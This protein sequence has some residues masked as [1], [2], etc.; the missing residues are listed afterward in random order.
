MRDPDIDLAD[1]LNAAGLFVMAG[2]ARRGRY[3]DFGSPLDA[4]KVTLAAELAGIGSP[5]ALK[6]RE[7]VIAGDFDG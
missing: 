4:P 3:N 7:R 2:A 6:L 5:A 1:A